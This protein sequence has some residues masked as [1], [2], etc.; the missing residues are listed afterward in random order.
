MKLS[1]IAKSNPNAYAIEF[2]ARK[3]GIDY[4]T[5]HIIEPNGATKRCDSCFLSWFNQSVIFYY[6]RRPAPQAFIQ[7]VKAAL[8]CV[9]PNYIWLHVRRSLNQHGLDVVKKSRKEDTGPHGEEEGE[10]AEESAES[11]TIHEET[12]PFGEK[13]ND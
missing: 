12:V 8:S 9:H 6:Y 4:M 2:V 7:D 1:S 5:S 13:E 3:Y 11:V 10:G